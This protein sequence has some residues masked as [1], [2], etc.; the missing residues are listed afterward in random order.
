MLGIK[1]EDGKI[2]F[3]VPIRN[4]DLIRI[5]RYNNGLNVDVNIH[6]TGTTAVPVD[7][8][9]GIGILSKIW[10]KITKKRLKLE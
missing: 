7:R 9:V 5:R 8:I 3:V 2:I 6:G 4:I 10:W 1:K